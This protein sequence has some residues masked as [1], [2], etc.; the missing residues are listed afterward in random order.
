MCNLIYSPISN[1]LLATHGYSLNQLSLW[2]C[3]AQGKLQK[4]D[5]LT[6]HSS[7]VLYLAGEQYGGRVVTGAGDQLLKLWNV[8]DGGEPDRSSDLR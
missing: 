5:A 6:G 7:R 8:F 1:E 2:K 3:G 4:A